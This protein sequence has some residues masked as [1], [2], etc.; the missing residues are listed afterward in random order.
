MFK[1]YCGSFHEARV[2]KYLSS[3][4]ND[5]KINILRSPVPLPGVAARAL[6]TIENLTVFCFESPMLV[7]DIT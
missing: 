7:R 4:W 2:I 3:T 1:S 6:P 5:D